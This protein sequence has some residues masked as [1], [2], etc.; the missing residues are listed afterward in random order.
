MEMI[1]THAGKLRAIGYDA[2]KRALRVTLE[3]G[4][5]LE[6]AN[7][8]ESLW[9]SLKNSSAQWSYYRDN[10]EEAFSCQRVSTQAAKPATTKPNPL[11]DLFQ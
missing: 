6:Y 8:G 10:I 1:H 4:S 3:D 11:D 2:A 9:R 5:T 7:V